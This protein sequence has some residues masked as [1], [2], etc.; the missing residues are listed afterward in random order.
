MCILQMV[1]DVNKSFNTLKAVRVLLGISA[2]PSTAFVSE[3]AAPVLQCGMMKWTCSWNL[4]NAMKYIHANRRNSI[5]I[6]F[7]TVARNA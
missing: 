1:L 3:T 5:R 7:V 2:V 6:I 4:S